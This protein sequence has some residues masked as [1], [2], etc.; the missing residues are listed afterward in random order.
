MKLAIVV[1]AA[2]ACGAK[3]PK[4]IASAK[5]SE[6]VVPAAHYAALFAQGASWRYAVTTTGEMY[7]PDEPKADHDG[8]VRDKSTADARCRVAEVRTWTDG[9][10]SRVEC[11]GFGDRDPITGAWAADADGLYKLEDLPAAGA[12]PELTEEALVIAAAPVEGRR[13][14]ADGT[15]FGQS[16]EVSPQPGGWCVTHSAWGGDESYTTL[17]FAKAGVTSGASGWSGG[18]THDTTFDLLR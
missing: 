12:A 10:M 14:D 4:P 16:T 13:G 3:A 17:C 7:D 11:D 15:E 5:A 6:P 8:M 2:A 1:V 18:S 9:V